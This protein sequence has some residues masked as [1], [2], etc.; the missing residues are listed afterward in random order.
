MDILSVYSRADRRLLLSLATVLIAAIAIADWFTKSYIAIGFLYLFPIMFVSGILLRWQIVAIALSCAVLQEA[1]GNLPKQDEIVR[2]VFSSVGYAGAGLSV[3]EL[4][5]NRR[6]VIR[7]LEE[8]ED[9]IRMRRDAEEQLRVLVESSPAA[10]LTVDSS[11]RILLANEAAQ[12]MLTLGGRDLQTQAIERYLPALATAARSRHPSPIR[13]TMQCTGQR[14][15]GEMFLAGIWFSTY[16]TTSGNRLAAI[17]VD[18]SEELVHREDLSLDYLLKNAR[19]LMSAVSHEIRNLSGAALVMHQNLTR[20]SALKQNDDFEALGTLIQ[21][22]EKLSNLDIVRPADGGRQAIELTSTLDEIRIL[23]ESACREAAAELS[24][25][26]GQSLPIVWADRYGLVQV[27]LNLA[28]NS[29]RAM[30]SSSVKKL[31]V[32]TS[33]DKEF[34]IV[35]ISDTGPGI[36]DPQSLFRPFQQQAK[37]SGLGLYVSQAIM[38]SFGGDLLFRPSASGCCFAVTMQLAFDDAAVR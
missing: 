23:I 8:V 19:I 33:E 35:R 31:T 21:G 1:F 30:G 24:W 10:I 18:L 16:S 37:A 11:G 32:N 27:F 14:A 15:D 36:S 12:E 20:V 26:I 25:E 13:T 5:R 6:N 29:L 7:H 9:Q 38:R 2:L 28:K 22:M 17:V 3:F 4:A 34:F